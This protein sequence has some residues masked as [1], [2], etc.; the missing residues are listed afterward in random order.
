MS[1]TTKSAEMESKKRTAV[2]PVI[3]RMLAEDDRE[4]MVDR[5]GRRVFTDDDSLCEEDQV[6]LADEHGHEIIRG[7]EAELEAAGYSIRD[8]PLT[9]SPL[10][11]L[12]AFDKESGRRISQSEVDIRYRV[13]WI[14]RKAAFTFAEIS[15]VMDT[16]PPTLCGWYDIACAIFGGGESLKVA[17]RIPHRA[18]TRDRY[19]AGLD[20]R[21][22]AVWI[23]RRAGV[24]NEEIVDTFRINERK[25]TRWYTAAC[26]IMGKKNVHLPSIV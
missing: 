10:D 15:G 7:S 23:L 18:A 5:S 1:E 13:V 16:P 17:R 25:V 6:V 8:M 24:T 4:N 3:A 21:H 14:L 20:K 22:L 11:S 12:E 2:D 19:P 9:F 26:A